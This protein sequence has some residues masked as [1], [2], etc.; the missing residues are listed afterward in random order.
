[1][2][3]HLD[4]HCKDNDI[5]LKNYHDGLKGQN[6]MTA[7]AVIKT[8][9]EKNYQENCLMVAASTAFRQPTIW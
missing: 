9:I 4:K 2:K 5:I 1:M 7:L 8:E 3:K 6:T